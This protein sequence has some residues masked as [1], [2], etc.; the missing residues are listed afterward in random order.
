MISGAYNR[1]WEEVESYAHPGFRDTA[2]VHDIRMLRETSGTG[3]HRS[4]RMEF[5]RG[6]VIQAR[7]AK[8]A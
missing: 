5:G 6:D 8:G 2:L 1:S 3:H 4:T 7:V